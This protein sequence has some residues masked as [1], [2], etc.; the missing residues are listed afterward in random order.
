MKYIKLVVVPLCLLMVILVGCGKKD[1][2]GKYVDDSPNAGERGDHKT[3]IELKK[4]GTFY[5]DDEGA[6]TDEGEY[7]VKDNKVILDGEEEKTTMKLLED[8]KYIKSDSLKLKKQ[9]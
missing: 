9:K 7:E 3:Y 1:V 5:Y 4:D 6:A 2:V 8:G